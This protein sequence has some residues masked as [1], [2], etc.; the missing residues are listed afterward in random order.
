V[1][2]IA[3]IIPVVQQDLFDNLLICIAKNTLLPNHIIII[4]NSGSPIII[5]QP[6]LAQVHIT[7]LDQ[8]KPLGV[9]ASWRLGFRHAAEYNLVSVLNDD[10]LISYDFF[11]KIRNASNQHPNASVFCPQTVKDPKTLLD[12]MDKG[13]A[14]CE[15]M[16]RREGWAFT[17]RGECLRGM[18]VIPGKLTTFCGDDWIFLWTSQIRRRPWM[19]VKNALAFHYGGVSLPNHKANGLLQTEKM[20]YQQLVSDL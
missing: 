1:K 8:D 12:Q 20:I 5:S 18:P 16:N 9:N 17:I 13:D 10:L 7:I 15:P 4:N 6:K 3:V 19:K 2:T 14:V 11:A